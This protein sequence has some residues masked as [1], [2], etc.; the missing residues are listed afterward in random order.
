MGRRHCLNCGRFLKRMWHGGYGA[1]KYCNEGCGFDLRERTRPL[2]LKYRKKECEICGK[3][4][5]NTNPNNYLLVHHKDCNQRNNNIENLITMCRECH[6]KE[7]GK[8]G[9]S[10]IK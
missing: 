1:K 6:G 2:Y 8:I 9:L 4:G 7:H 3:E 10:I 5:E